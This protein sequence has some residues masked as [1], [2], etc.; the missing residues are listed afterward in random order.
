MVDAISRSSDFALPNCNTPL[1][2]YEVF[3][4][5]LAFSARQSV[6]PDDQLTLFYRSPQMPTKIEREASTGQIRRPPPR[7]KEEHGIIACHPAT[8]QHQQ[9][10]LASSKRV[11]TSLNHFVIAEELHD[12]TAIPEREAAS[13]ARGAFTNSYRAIR[14]RTRSQPYCPLD[15]LS[16]HVWNPFMPL[17][18]GNPRFEGR[19][20]QL[21]YMYLDGSLLSD[22][23]HQR[24]AHIQRSVIHTR[25]QSSFVHIMKSSAAFHALIA[26][27]ETSPDKR[28][29]HQDE[30]LVRWHIGQAL[31]I[32]NLQL[33]NLQIL[34]SDGVLV[35]V[36]LL[37]LLAQRMNDVGTFHAHARGLSLLMKQRRADRL[38]KPTSYDHAPDPQS[39]QSEWHNVPSPNAYIGAFPEPRIPCATMA[40][41]QVAFSEMVNKGLVSSE[42]ARAQHYNI[43]INRIA[44]FARSDWILALVASQH[45]WTDGGE[46]KWPP[47]EMACQGTLRLCMH[48]NVWPVACKPCTIALNRAAAM[49]H[50]LRQINLDMLFFQCPNLLVWIA[51]VCGPHAVGYARRWWSYVL[52]K[53]QSLSNLN[54]FK[55]ALALFEK[56]YAWSSAGTLAAEVFWVAT[57]FSTAFQDALEPKRPMKYWSLA[58][59]LID[60]ASVSPITYA[61]SVW[62][63]KVNILEVKDAEDSLMATVAENAVCSLL[64]DGSESWAVWTPP[65]P[66][67]VLNRHCPAHGVQF[68]RK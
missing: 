42:F 24:A 5:D 60:D 21:L 28:M 36:L 15:R 59:G 47:L 63:K 11:G 9:Q 18:A 61:S 50:Y 55:D 29:S 14:P 25:Q 38:V 56:Q 65:S 16:I 37:M 40:Y 51:L 34:D 44:A 22:M 68:D 13:Y 46:P 58:K 23:K 66:P 39:S 3:L 52:Q 41:K 53:A 67:C 54:T 43:V 1:V 57:V 32:T 48:I 49:R 27:L 64:S 45:I 17:P 31:A 6:C 20:N 2:E 26:Y 33:A 4:Q 35:T 12:D 10:L 30:A 62:I 19:I 7:T 8:Q